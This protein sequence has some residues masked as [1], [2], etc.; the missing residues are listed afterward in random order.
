[1]SASQSNRGSAAIVSKQQSSSHHARLGVICD[2]V[3]ENWPSMDLVADMLL[4]QLRNG[5]P[6]GIDVERIRPPMARRFTR[7]GCSSSKLAFSADRLFNRFWDYPRFLRTYREAFDVFH[8]VDHSYAQLVLELPPGRTLVTCHD[9]DAFRCLLY[10]DGVSSAP[11]RAMARRILRGLRMAALVVC[12]S[13]ATYDMLRAHNLIAKEKLR[14]VPL[15]AHP[16]CSAQPDRPADLQARLLLGEPGAGGANLLH[17]GS[18]VP[19]KR[20]D[21]LLRIFAQV[22]NQFPGVRLVH[23]GG[24]LTPRQESIVDEL[25]LRDSV[26]VLPWLDRQ[27]LAAV[28]RQAT[29]VLLPSE[30][31]GFGLPVI[32]AMACGTPV[33]ASDLLALREVG[34]DSAIYCPVSNAANWTEA[35]SG[36]LLE[37]HDAPDAWQA[38]RNRAILQASRFTWTNYTRRMVTIYR[39]VLSGVSPIF[40]EFASC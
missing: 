9:T 25:K 3:E 11:F 37:R 21:F 23:V 17:V 4:A 27:V 12:P 14:V 36:L 13:L 18:T 16:S 24:Q 6:T 40:G 33:V 32:E 39:E 28:Y 20:I 31:E 1:M 30:R 29:A 34:G 8:V 22:K 2:F 38:R 15:G 35:I 10:P 7:E 5:P 26:L 19:R